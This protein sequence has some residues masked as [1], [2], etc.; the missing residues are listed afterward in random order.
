MESPA[1]T[2]QPITGSVGGRPTYPT[3]GAGEQLPLPDAPAHFS[4]VEPGSQNASG[5]SSASLEAISRSNEMRQ[6]GVQRV[7]YNRGGLRRVV[8]NGVD[9]ADVFPAHGETLVEEGPAGRRV[10]QD[11]GGF[12]PRQEPVSA[13]AA[14]PTPA[15]PIDITPA[16]GASNRPPNPRIPPK[17]TALWQDLMPKWKQALAAQ[18][19]DQI[20]FTVDPREDLLPFA[21]RVMDEDPRTL[22]GAERK[23]RAAVD[24]G[25]EGSASNELLARLGIAG[26]GAVGG[27]LIDKEHPGRGAVLGLAA[28]AGIPA[29]IRNPE[30]LEKL[31]YFSML[32]GPGTQAKNL[33]GNAGAVTARA[34]EE[35]LGGDAGKAKRILGSFF[36]R[37]TGDNMRDAFLHPREEGAWGDTSGAIGVPGRIMGAVDEGTMGAL[38]RA[39][40]PDSEAHLTAFRGDPRSEVG[41]AIAE[42]PARGGTYGRLALPFARTATNILERGIERTPGLGSLPAVRAMTR[43]SAKEALIRQMV[44]AGAGV[45]GY[46]VGDENPYVGAA[47]GPYALPFG[48][49]AA[50]GAASRK[51]GSGLRQAQAAVK[52]FGQSV[53]LPSDTAITSPGD[54]PAQ[55]VP[56]GLTFLGP[57]LPP[58]MTYDTSAEDVPGWLANK[59]IAKIPW[60]N[61]ML[62]TKRKPQPR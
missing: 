29:L 10:V 56:N 47:L 37:E 59:S 43:A 52:T 51:G 49:G 19:G 4:T 26:A 9:A 42:F 21:K 20:P 50:A 46:E 12:I 25:E 16:D 36:S 58:D 34:V 11:N 57:Q 53:P 8:G 41:R 55:F 35:G 5:E 62:R 17:I 22:M 3:L 23:V 28:G 1:D 13:T 7:I 27:S 39:G 45:A 14:E 32:S 2:G 33:I 40:L 18:E 31:R 61:Q 48:I 60:L 44:G 15:P 38:R 30:A 6:A 54:L 24:S